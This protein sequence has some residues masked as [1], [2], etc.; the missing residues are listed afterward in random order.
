LIGDDRL[1]CRVYPLALQLLVV[2]YIC[3]VSVQLTGF[4]EGTHKQIGLKMI[5]C[6]VQCKLS[7]EIALFRLI[8]SSVSDQ[9]EKAYFGITNTLQELDL[10]IQ[11]IT[12]FN[13]PRFSKEPSY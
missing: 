13:K 3:F 1:S 11:L 6:V 7:S 12:L 10:L 2:S 4:S 9:Y 8:V 5:E